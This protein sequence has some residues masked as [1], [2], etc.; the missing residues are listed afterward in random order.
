MPVGEDPLHV[1]GDHQ[2]LC[3]LTPEW[4]VLDAVDDRRAVA[5]LGKEMFV[6]PQPVRAPDLS[7]HK[8]VGRLPDLDLRTPPHWDS[9]PAD[10]IVDESAGRHGDGPRG[11][12]LEP[13]PGWRQF[14]EVSGLGEKAEHLVERC[15]QNDFILEMEGFHCEAPAVANAAI[16]RTRPENMIL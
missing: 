16:F 10:P 1:S 13:K 14:F 2:P 15:R 4:R 11:Q 5:P 9:S 12:D 6:A 3:D 8:A 7:I